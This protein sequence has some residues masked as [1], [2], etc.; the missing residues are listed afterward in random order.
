MQLHSS[1]V[2][3][4][5]KHWSRLQCTHSAGTLTRLFRRHNTEATARCIINIQRAPVPGGEKPPPETSTTHPGQCQCWH[6]LHWFEMERSRTPHYWAQ[7]GLTLQH[8]RNRRHFCCLPPAEGSTH[9]LHASSHPSVDV[10]KLQ[11][12][13]TPSQCS[14]VKK[15]HSQYVWIWTHWMC[16]LLWLRQPNRHSSNRFAKPVLKE[17]ELPA[18]KDSKGNWF[19]CKV[20]EILTYFPLP[21]KSPIKTHSLKPGRQEYVFFCLNM[22]SSCHGIKDSTMRSLRY[23][24]TL[25]DSSNNLLSTNF[26]FI[27]NVL[28][29]NIWLTRTDVNIKR[30]KYSRSSLPLF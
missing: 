24:C 12:A 5:G 2:L 8:F 30:W 19:Y 4:W 1:P 10:H 11:C 27:R 17:S 21:P 7:Q 16:V 15:N 25:K 20:W 3:P 23:I 28:S 18:A 13:N 6:P 26:I 22:R 9:S 29:C 14:L